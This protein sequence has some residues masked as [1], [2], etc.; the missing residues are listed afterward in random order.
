MSHFYLDKSGMFIIAL[1]MMSLRENRLTTKTVSLY[2]LICMCEWTYLSTWTGITAS[3]CRVELINMTKSNRSSVSS[4]WMRCFAWLSIDIM[5]GYF[6]RNKE[7][8]RARQLETRKKV[9]LKKQA[10]DP[11]L[12]HF[13]SKLSAH[14]TLTPQTLGTYCSLV[15]TTL[16]HSNCEHRSALRASHNS[17]PVQ[18]HEA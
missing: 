15:E 2:S 6:Q 18:L 8:R 3:Q 4:T 17:D 7:V 5:S 16:S 10:A 9:T 13:F 12:E 11:I 1:Q 14:S